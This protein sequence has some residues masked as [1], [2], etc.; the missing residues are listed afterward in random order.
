MGKLDFW[1]RTAKTRMHSISLVGKIKFH[2][3]LE[4]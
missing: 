3:E 2:Y 4:R 1:C